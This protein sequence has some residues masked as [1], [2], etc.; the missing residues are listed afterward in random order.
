MSP[1][2]QARKAA[3][4]LRHCATGQR[5]N[6]RGAHLVALAKPL[7]TNGD[8]RWSFRFW[9]GPCAQA[10]GCRRPFARAFP[11]QAGL[12]HR[13]QGSLPSAWTCPSIV[14]TDC[15]SFS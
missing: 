6:G 2:A 8:A 9:M 4:V 15:V 10:M 14:Q 1:A 12:H 13:S 7:L 11:E 5:A 3:G